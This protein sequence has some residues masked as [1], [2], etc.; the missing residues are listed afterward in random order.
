MD[1]PEWFLPTGVSVSASGYSG[2]NYQQE[3][4]LKIHLSGCVAPS[5]PL[6]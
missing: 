4:Y 2:K 3:D 5:L 1:E 6:P